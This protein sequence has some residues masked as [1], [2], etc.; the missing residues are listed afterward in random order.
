MKVGEDLLLPNRMNPFNG[1]EFHNPHFLS[2]IN[3]PISFSCLSASLPLRLSVAPW[4][5]GSVRFVRSPVGERT[6]AGVTNRTRDRF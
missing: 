4:L 5:R 1:L 2:T 3:V 6:A